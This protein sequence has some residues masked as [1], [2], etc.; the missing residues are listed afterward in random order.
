[1]SETMHRQTTTDGAAEGNGPTNGGLVGIENLG[2]QPLKSLFSD[3][4]KDVY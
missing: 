3:V 4:V 2:P 1:M